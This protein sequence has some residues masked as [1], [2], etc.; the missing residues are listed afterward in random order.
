MKKLRL[1][2][3]IAVA[4]GFSIVLYL[5]VLVFVTPNY[6]LDSTPKPPYWVNPV[7]VII[8]LIGSF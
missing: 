2:G 7:A 5:V 3:I 1:A 6:N 4:I 8:V